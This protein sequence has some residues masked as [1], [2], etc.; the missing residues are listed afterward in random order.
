MVTASYR[1]R[2]PGH[3]YYGK[4]TYLITLVVSGREP[5]LS[6]LAGDAAHP[7]VQLSPLGKVVSE[8]W[9]R[10]PQLQA[11]HGNRVA[12]HA[13]VCM[14]DHFHGVIEVLEP[15]Q[16]C[17]GDIMQA[18][19]S[20]CTS[21]WQQAQGLG[22]SVNRPILVDCH[23]P[24]APAWLREKAK[25]F[26]D[27]GSLV[28]NLSKKQRQEYY[29]LV[30]REHRPLFDDNY[31]D[32]VCLDE[33]HR[34]AMIAYVHDNPRRAILRRT[35]P[36]VMRRC[37]HVQ[38]GNRTFGTFGNLFLLRWANRLQVQ[39]HRRHPDSGLPFETTPDYARLH[40]AWVAAILGGATVIVTPGV[41]RGELLMKNECLERGFPLIHLQKEPIGPF[42]KPE[43]RR[44]DACA[45]G[46]LLILAPWQLDQMQPVNNVPADT[47]YSRFHNLNAL[48]NEICNFCGNAK[49]LST[50]H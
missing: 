46:S 31:D 22:A 35:L 13:C 24:N 4:G 6:R 48:A 23:G 15:M 49:I 25:R 7:E 12:V 27:E 41:S 1:P 34:Q 42:W 5:L 18:F 28:N 39:C 50:L 44:F 33:R 26:Q 45:A 10:I 32:T 2:N 19:K 43:Q 14:P 8:K 3:D 17:L 40:D 29:T 47:N 37:L 38:I 20:A 30:G 21:W 36:D 16:W 11:K 9:G